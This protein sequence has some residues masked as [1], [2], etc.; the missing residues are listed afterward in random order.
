MIIKTFGGKKEKFKIRPINKNDKE[1]V[2]NFII[3]NWGTEKVVAHGKIFYPHKLSGFIAFKENKYLGLL[4]YYIK[5][6]ELE[7]IT[8]NSLVRGRG[9]GSALLKVVEKIAHKFK[10]K[11]IWLITTNDNIDAL[12]FYQ[13]R[14]FSIVAIHRNAI[15]ISRK[16]KPEIPLIGNYGIPIRDEIELEKAIKSF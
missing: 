12:R 9:I 3:K 14:G 15:K 1:W 4:T 11:K 7:I 8:M 5:R 10:C 6:K 13:M 2:R 16:L